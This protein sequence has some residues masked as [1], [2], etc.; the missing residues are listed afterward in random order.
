MP[1]TV[2][3]PPAGSRDFRISGMD[4]GDCA[5][6]IE[7]TVARMP[8][9]T[10]VSVSLIGGRMSVDLDGAGSD[11]VAVRE[12]VA[13]LGFG[14]TEDRTDEP[15]GHGAADGDDARASVVR[16][17]LRAWTHGSD[18][19]T[20]IASLLLVVAV[21]ADLL[22]GA[23]QALAVALYVAPVVVG[24]VTIAR[25][26]VVG[27]WASRSPDM[28]LL[29]TIA[30]V[31]AAAIGA[32]AEAALVVVLFSIGEALE[33]RAVGR[34][35]RELES[36]VALTPDT[37]RVLVSGT[38]DDGCAHE[39]EELR[40]ARDVRIGDRIVVL[41]GDRVPTDGTIAEGRSS[42]DQAA[43]TGESVPVDREPGD[44]VFA[45]TINGEGRLVVDVTVAPGD[46]TLDR[47][48]RLV[49]EAQAQRSPAE[50]WVTRFAQIYTPIVIGLAVAVAVLP[51]LLGLLSFGDAFYAALALL[52]LA[53][54]CA[55]VLSTPVSIVS[56]LGRAS[57]AGVLV[58]GGA[59]LER[60]ATV[61]TVAFDK[62]G[63]L[64]EG[65]PAVTHVVPFG[66]AP[67]EL[68][69]VAAAVEQGSAHPLATAIV[70]AARGADP[71]PL[72]AVTDGRALTGLGAVGTVQGRE[73]RVGSP[74]LL[75]P[76]D[77]RTAAVVA[78]LRNAGA[79]VVLV[80][81]DGR[82]IGALGLADQPRASA[83]EAIGQLAR[84]GIDA[85]VMLTG[86]HPATARA[87]ATDL[88]IRDVRADLLP[89]DKATAV[90]GLG[91]G[92]A[93]VGDGVNDA[94]ALARADIGLAM[95]S[96]GS[97]TAIEVADVALLGDD[98]RKVAGLIGLA[99]WTRAVVRQNIAFSL[100]TKLIAAVFLLF[101]ALPLWAAVGVD[102]GASLIVVAN[103][104][105]LVN[106]HP[107]GRARRLPLLGG[108]AS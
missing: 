64:T 60:A 57:A 41:P 49:A 56:A 72:P 40:P 45:G 83:R 51:T 11:A 104:L 12:R 32:W 79:T 33:R 23:S 88:G 103:G 76:G 67:D 3:P 108:F 43:I 63:T 69:R 8:G 24:G 80:E 7:R 96:A 93:M 98:P 48:G 5:S 66:V 84:L 46:T 81:R 73:I 87:V 6:R 97:D 82:I 14:I 90:S 61:R 55:L 42:L 107:L 68:L 100:G 101:G 16:R 52:I 38:C 99:R 35:R 89:E 27:S 25:T 34:A 10:A 85:T 4:C 105:R 28:N 19:I 39:R 44:A 92:V 102:V 13:Q 31:G 30:V 65:A 95:G 37:A 9:V 74:R 75:A 62:T 86:D 54:P 50:R 78:E 59:H 70:A 47:I 77:D 29:M 26:G 17:A 106:G 1:T 18:A 36:L 21:V 71:R 20:A 2:P 94:P 15:P 53:C 91:A 22:L 58:K